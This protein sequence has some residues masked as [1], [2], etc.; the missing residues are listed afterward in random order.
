MVRKIF[1][2]YLKEKDKHRYYGSLQALFNHFKNL[3]VSKFTIDRYDFTEPFENEKVI[4]RKG[5]FLTTG[6]VKGKEE[7]I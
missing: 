2:L 5:Q 3:G 6:D 1:H 4:I 7:N